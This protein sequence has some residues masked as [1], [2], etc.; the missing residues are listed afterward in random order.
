M[1]QN[2][3]MAEKLVDKAVKTV[4]YIAELYAKDLRHRI[5][6]TSPFLLAKIIPACM[7][8]G[9]PKDQYVIDFLDGK[10]FMKAL[11][12]FGSANLLNSNFRKTLSDQFRGDYLEGIDSSLRDSHF[13]G[14]EF[15][16][17][18]SLDILRMREKLYCLTALEYDNAYQRFYKID[19]R[20]KD[21][22]EYAVII[23]DVEEFLRCVTTA[24]NNL[25]EKWNDQF[26]L[27]YKR[28]M[29][30]VDLYKKQGYGEFCKTWDYSWQKEF[31]IVLDMANGK[32]Y[33]YF[34]LRGE[35]REKYIEEHIERKNFKNDD[36]YKWAKE[37]LLGYPE[38]TDYAMLTLPGKIEIDTNPDSI[39]DF[40]YF[41]IGNISSICVRVPTSEL[42]E[43]TD[44]PLLLGD[45][46]KPPIFIPPNM[47]PREPKPTFFFGVSHIS[48]MGNV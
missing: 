1:P 8:T 28:V 7:E 4:C 3:Q 29:Y 18:G 14:A 9:K 41:D 17:F 2:L 34:I 21:F 5:A 6:E 31:R 42:I 32:F 24:F 11:D 36:D 38:P 35:E 44:L 12:Q 27:G 47:P 43:C 10:L 46:F 45:K 16:A 15:D 25:C 26:W 19:S 37:W 20:L 22:G 33:P 39:K 48:A 30:N 40:F 23:T 13:I